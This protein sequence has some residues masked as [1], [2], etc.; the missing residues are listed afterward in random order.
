MVKQAI[1]TSVFLV[2]ITLSSRPM[3]AAV[4]W[5]TD[6]EWMPL[7]YPSSPYVGYDLAGD[8]NPATVDL[9]GGELGGSIYP[10]A[11]YFVKDGYLMYRIR[12]NGQANNSQ[13]V[14]QVF[15]DTD[16]DSPDEL[17][18]Y[19]LQLVL[20]G[21]YEVQFAAVDQTTEPVLSAILI[22]TSNVLWSG[23]PDTY[24]RYFQSADSNFSG[25][26]DYFVDLAMPYAPLSNLFGGVEMLLLRAAITTSASQSVI[27][28]D[29]SLNLSGSD[30]VSD[31][32]SNPVVVPEPR[33][34]TMLVGLSLMA[35][36]A[37]RFRRR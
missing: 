12:V 8:K 9:V 4:P 34:T 31:I 6:D 25:N 10:M 30:R 29:Y 22:D 18:D 32:L 1:L 7:S 2:A 23:S 13:S 16:D 14:W 28:K 26:A 21:G 3:M 24:A 15:F 27:N 11:Y 5:P 19:V 17:F 20:S 37:T 36:A 35:F 33:A